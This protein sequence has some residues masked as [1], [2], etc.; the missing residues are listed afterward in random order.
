MND[1]IRLQINI[2]TKL[3]LVIFLP[4]DLGEG[5]APVRPHAED[6]WVE[7]EVFAATAACTKVFTIKEN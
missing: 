7:V 4:G 1:I 3:H 2:E 6:H 5:A